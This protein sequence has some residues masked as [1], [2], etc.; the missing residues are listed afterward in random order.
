MIPFSLLK[1]AQTLSRI[2]SLRYIAVSGACGTCG[3]AITFLVSV[4]DNPTQ[5][6]TRFWESTAIDCEVNQR[7]NS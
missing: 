4:D 2:S 6:F 1:S 5:S 3:K 7:L